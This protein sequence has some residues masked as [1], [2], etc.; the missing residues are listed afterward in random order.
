MLVYS[1]PAC[2]NCRIKRKVPDEPWEET[3]VTEGLVGV[4][5]VESLGRSMEVVD[6]ESWEV[7]GSGLL[8][9]LGGVS[10]GDGVADGTGWVGA[11][12]RSRD[13]MSQQFAL[14]SH[15]VEVCRQWAARL[16]E[17]EVSTE[18]MNGRRH[19]IAPSLRPQHHRS[20]HQDRQ[21]SNRCLGEWT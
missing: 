5:G 12:G 18:R 9:A 4:G 10:G 21:P 20:Q 14:P 6:D 11:E 2:C 19:M 15:A 17:Q 1:A 8:G 3:R 13:F 7:C 16:A